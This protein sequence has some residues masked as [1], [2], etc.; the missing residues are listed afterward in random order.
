[1]TESLKKDIKKIIC[2]LLEIDNIS[3]D[4]IRDDLDK[5]DSLKHIEIVFALEE[6]FDVTFDR[7]SLQNLNSVNSIYDQIISIKN[8]A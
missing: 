8:A 7:D 6:S 3:D 5:W 2:E 4:L 1:M